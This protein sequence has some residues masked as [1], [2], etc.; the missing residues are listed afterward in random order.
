MR[1]L[2]SC[3]AQF[4]FDAPDRSRNEQEFAGIAGRNR[5]LTVRLHG[6]VPGAKLHLLIAEELDRYGTRARINPS[7]EQI[8]Y[9]HQC[10]ARLGAIHRRRAAERDPH[11]NCNA[12]GKLVTTPVAQ[13]RVA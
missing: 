5:H 7:R 10:T 3:R 6:N 1:R 9:C 11:A 8:G 12:I 2:D 13:P 4:T